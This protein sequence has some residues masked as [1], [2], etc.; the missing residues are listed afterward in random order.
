MSQKCQ[1]GA[2][3]LRILRGLLIFI[4]AWNPEEGG[5]NVCGGIPQDRTD[6]LATETEGKQAKSI[7]FLPCPFCRILREGV[8]SLWWLSLSQIT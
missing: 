3:V 5:F 2:G 4:P 7:F 1:S 8:S 6:E